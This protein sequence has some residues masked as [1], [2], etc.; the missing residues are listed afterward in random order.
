MTIALLY[1]MALIINALMTA[2]F[3][4]QL[5]RLSRSHIQLGYETAEALSVIERYMRNNPTPPRW[6]DDLATDLIAGKVDTDQS[7]PPHHPPHVA[8]WPWSGG[9]V[10]LDDNDD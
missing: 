1:A 3:A 4:H 9:P 10:I 6:A 8:G 7:T 5:L 2:G